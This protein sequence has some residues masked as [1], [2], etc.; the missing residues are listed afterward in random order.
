MKKLYSFFL[1]CFLLFS[2]F[3]FGTPSLERY[4]YSCS[5]TGQSLRQE[6]AVTR[7]SRADIWL[8]KQQKR[9]KRLKYVTEKLLSTAPLNA[10]SLL[11]CFYLLSL[12]SSPVFQRSRRLARLR[13][14]PAR[15]RS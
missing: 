6:D 14:P 10:V 12:F 4:F 1:S 15:F 9:F 3:Y 8:G 11:F 2:C 13:A 7:G 5:E